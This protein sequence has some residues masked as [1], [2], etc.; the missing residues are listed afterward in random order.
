[1]SKK[2]KILGALG[3]IVCVGALATATYFA[4]PEITNKSWSEMLNIGISKPT[5]E[6]P[7][8]EEYSL[9]ITAENVTYICTDTTGKTYTEEKKKKKKWNGEEL[10]FVVTA[11][12]GYIIDSV[13]V[14]NEVIVLVDNSFTVTMNK[15]VV[16]D[17]LTNELPTFI[18]IEGTLLLDGYNNFVVI[19]KSEEGYKY[20]SGYGGSVGK[21]Y[22]VVL[23]DVENEI[24]VIC[25]G[26]DRYTL[27]DFKNQNYLYFNS[28][29]GGVD[30]PDEEPTGTIKYVV[31]LNRN[32]PLG[33]SLNITEKETGLE[34]QTKYLE[35]N[36]EYEF[37]VIPEENVVVSNFIINNTK[38]NYEDVVSLTFNSGDFICNVNVDVEILPVQYTI[39]YDE[40]LFEVSFDNGEFDGK[41]LTISRDAYTNMNMNL[42]ADGYTDEFGQ[43]LNHKIVVSWGENEIEYS[44]INELYFNIDSSL[45][46]YEITITLVETSEVA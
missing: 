31:M 2:K 3:A 39:N 42:I 30:I 33:V 9:K 4:V 19:Q 6:N 41:I 8:K 24:V 36:K 28:N 22:D 13:T 40:S 14:N 34:V 23:E 44:N 18:D 29:N 45:G 25:R 7:T 15:N 11:N 10:T 17:I 20:F 16:I 26:G 46:A 5:P 1:M 12:Y 21:T 32:V 37:K 38:Y 35:L 43:L 27:L